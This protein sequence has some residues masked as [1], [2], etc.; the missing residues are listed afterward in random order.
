M[1]RLRALLDAQRVQA[2]TIAHVSERT[3]LEEEIGTFVRR[4][5]RQH[6]L[7]TQLF[8][9]PTCKASRYI[10]THTLSLSLTLSPTHS[11]TLSVCLPLP[12]AQP[13]AQHD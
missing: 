11:L 9:E 1:T 5:Y 13:V 12:L 7:S 8:A 10:H 3:K 2:A 6:R 4:A